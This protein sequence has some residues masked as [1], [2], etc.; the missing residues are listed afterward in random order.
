MDIIAHPTKQQ[1]AECPTLDDP[2]LTCLE[3]YWQTLRRARHIPV[4]NDL[5]PNK[6][7]SALPYTFILQRVAP[8]TARFRVA[9]QRIYDLLKMDARGM[10]FSTLFHSNTRDTLR[11]LLENAFC[12]P[13]IVGLPL[14]SPATVLRPA[15]HGAM[16]LLP[17][18]DDKGQTN[19]L[20]G[21]FV[22]PDTPLSRPRRF[23][24]DCHQQIRHEPLGP[25]R[26]A[27]PLTP[28]SPAK[29]KRPDALKQP[30]LR[31]IINNG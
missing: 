20:L 6:I 4:R 25:K 13:A 16:I 5:N 26:A 31:L 27:I 2:I 1:Q 19:R 8:G 21:A 28:R 3:Q 12:E 14:V 9:G 11:D 15:M 23:E 7:D 17:M 29:R 30:A 22:T 18:Q 10:P 24:L